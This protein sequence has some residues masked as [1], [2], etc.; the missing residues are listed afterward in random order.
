[1]TSKILFVLLLWAACIGQ[2]LAQ[3]GSY[4]DSPFGIMAAFDPTTLTTISASDKIVW[5]G[6]KF[7][8]LG[9]KWSRGAGE[10]TFWGT[11]E[12]V[13]GAGYDWSTSDDVLKKVYQN[14]GENF[15]MVVIISSQ[16]VK[17]GSSD[18]PSA[19]EQ[20]FI[21]YVKAFVERYD[22]DG[23][24]DYD[25]I[26]K[27]K[28]WQMSNEPFPNHWED[29]GGTIDGYV[30]F[31]ELTHNAIKEADPD[32][33]IILGTFQFQTNEQIDKL[34]EVISK[35]AIK[36]KKLFD[37]A[38]THFWESGNNYKIPLVDA[39]KIFDDN[40]Y[41]DIGYMTLEFGTTVR[42]ATEKDQANYLI[43]GFV[44]NM[45]QGFTLINW[46]NLVE[47]N[48]FGG[49]PNSIYNYMGLI[50]D[51]INGDPIPAGTK[52]LSYYTYK[53]MVEVLEGS[54]WKNIA[55]IQEQNGIHI[56]KFTKPFDGAQCKPVWVAWNDSS[57]TRTI[58]I[59]GI[60][61][62]RVK[63]TEAVPKYESGKDV[64]DYTTAF[65]T[66]TLV[67][68]NGAAALTLG[69]RPVFIEPLTVTSVEYEGENIPKEF[70]LYQNYPNPFNPTTTIQ[71]SLTLSLSQWERV[72][73]GRVRVTLKVFD[74]LGREVATLVD[75][76]LNPGEHSVVYDAK[77]LP[78]GVY[79][80][81]LSAG[82]FTETKKMLITK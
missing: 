76:E 50:A 10:K 1:M 55:T 42:R 75:G 7:R 77:G 8:D 36:N 28:Y 5:A 27:V 16:R 63:A 32:A 18:I 29:A 59:S 81:R 39:K 53:K 62:D 19:D 74:V 66:D 31:A 20:Y 37:Y 64:A 71:F 2:G 69:Q 73:E 45:A 23:T 34:N 79:F 22:G 57:V 38:D 61:S 52:R 46:N 80:Y 48:A 3:G 56:Y 11:N 58:T 35:S 68:T 24:A 72:S 51:G 12:P 65:Q 67:V 17:G 6:E 9:A 60:S 47:W 14:G 21:N 49:N 70:I 30:R 82:S 44:S 25:T 13:L 15:N 40:G 26:I 33:K 43:K 78:S 54:D 41:S 4:A